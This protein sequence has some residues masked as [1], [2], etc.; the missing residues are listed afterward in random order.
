MLIGLVRDSVMQCFCH[1]CR[2]PV[3][4]AVGGRSAIFK[5]PTKVRSIQP[6]SSKKVKFITTEIRCQEKS[7]GGLSYEVILAEPSGNVVGPVTMR[8][9]TKSN[10][11]L[12]NDE[13]A[14]KLKEAEERRLSL[15][16]KK[17]A[18]WSAKANKIEE[19]ARKK[20][21]LNNDFI[22]QTKEALDAKMEHHVE[23]RDALMT[24]LKK[25]LKDHSEEIEK[26][27]SLLEQQKEVERLAIDEKHKIAA[28]IRDE[29][30]K[31][32]LTNLKEHN[33][34]KLAE[35]KITADIRETEKCMEIKHIF[36]NKLYAAEQKRE[37]EFRK[38]LE[39]L[40]EHERHAEMVRQNKARAAQMDELMNN[41]NSVMSN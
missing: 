17:M 31:K 27:K 41:E 7:K 36:D 29:N 33:I 16:A 23:K 24:D 4:P 9:N 19:I 1:T 6:K 35:V 21:E 26:K 30:M 15:E 11:S 25:K 3:L 10:K 37:E 22:I 32:M 18:D 39:K 14:K 13:I 28:T 5:K 12:S 38:K 20:D 40:R 8:N 2:A 34:N